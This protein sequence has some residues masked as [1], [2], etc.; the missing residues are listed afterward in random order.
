[1]HFHKL[2]F[3][4]RENVFRHD[5]RSN[6]L[7]LRSAYLA[8]HCYWTVLLLIQLEG[9]CESASVYFLPHSFYSSCDA[10]LVRGDI[11]GRKYIAQTLISL[12]RVMSVTL[13]RKKTSIRLTTSCKSLLSLCLQSSLILNQMDPVRNCDP[14]LTSESFQWKN[15]SKHREFG[16]YQYAADPWSLFAAGDKKLAST[17]L[18]KLIFFVDCLDTKFLFP[19]ICNEEIVSQSV[20]VFPFL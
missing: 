14:K 10:Q 9:I 2:S 18:S 20:C 16:H 8:L 4:P 17:F 5:T 13:L 12:Q 19:Q 6:Q 3:F 1:M 11:S 7:A 15:K